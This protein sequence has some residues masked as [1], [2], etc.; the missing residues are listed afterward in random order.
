MS[1]KRLRVGELLA[2]VGAACVLVALFERNYEAP[3][4][5]LDAWETFGPGVGL[6]LAGVCAALAMGLGGLRGRGSALPVSTA[7]WCVLLGLVASIAALVRA[8]ER[9]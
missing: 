7:V 8:L 5:N 9:P 4:G 6:L 3:V 1:L 2:L